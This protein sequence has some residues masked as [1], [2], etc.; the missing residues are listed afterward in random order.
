MIAAGDERPRN[1][2]TP[3]SH[4]AAVFAFGDV[5]AGVFALA[6]CGSVVGADGTPEGAA[7]A[8][9]LAGERPAF[10]HAAGGPRDAESAGD[11]SHDGVRTSVVEPLARW[12]LALTSGDDCLELDFEAVCQ[13]VELDPAAHGGLHGYE[14]LCRVRGEARLDGVRHELAC[15]GQRG[16][17]WGRIADGVALGRTLSAWFAEDLATSVAALRPASVSHHDGEAVDAWLLDDDTGTPHHVN[18]PLLSTTYDGDGRQLRAGLELWV[19]EEDEFPRRAAGRSLGGASLPLGDGRFDVT[20]MA[21]T[22][23]GHS[24]VGPYAVMH[25]GRR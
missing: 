3:G 8:V 7:L 4:D 5:G 16:H 25:R 15:L 23:E 6:R 22:M 10:A 13:A 2:D 9:V 24:G 21:W 17:Q 18:E 19:G 1:D 12:E 14:Q 20:F 11:F